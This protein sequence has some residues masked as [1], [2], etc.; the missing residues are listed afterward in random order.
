MNQKTKQ[1]NNQTARERKLNEISPS[2]T[3]LIKV[4]LL[5]A[6]KPSLN[7]SYTGAL[8]CLRVQRLLFLVSLLSAGTG[9]A[10]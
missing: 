1:P 3:G 5:Q 9:G 10:T 4:Q 2:G 7:A 6:C 8:G